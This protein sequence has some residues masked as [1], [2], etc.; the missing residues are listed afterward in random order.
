MAFIQSKGGG[1]TTGS[2]VGRRAQTGS[3][4]ITHR[5]LQVG[6]HTDTLIYYN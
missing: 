1:A 5:H 4:V 2:D 6:R 3:C